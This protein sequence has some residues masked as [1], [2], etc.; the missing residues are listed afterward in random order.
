MFLLSFPLKTRVPFQL[1]SD[2]VNDT[3]DN[4][5][6]N[7]HILNKKDIIKGEET[8]VHTN[9]LPILRNKNRSG[10]DE[11]FVNQ[12]NKY[13]VSTLNKIDDFYHKMEVLRFL[14]NNSNHI[15]DKIRRIELLDRDHK[16]SFLYDFMKGG[17]FREWDDDIF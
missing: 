14:Q 2:T 8:W 10:L 1:R 12:G 9:E 13:D 17:L 15:S 6:F 5:L 3:T 7:N 16:D 11:R 4:H